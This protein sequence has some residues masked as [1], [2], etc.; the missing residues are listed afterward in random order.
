MRSNARAGRR[1][2]LIECLPSKGGGY[3]LVESTNPAN[4]PIQAGSPTSAATRATGMT[5]G[6]A[7]SLEGKL[8]R[9]GGLWPV[10]KT[11]S[12]NGETTVHRTPS[13]GRNEG[14]VG[15]Q[16]GKTNAQVVG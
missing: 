11:L 9:H 1:F 12:G 5:S 13:L 8:A 10:P 6:V 4:F 15:S 3:L 7:A 2:T 14:L 16:S